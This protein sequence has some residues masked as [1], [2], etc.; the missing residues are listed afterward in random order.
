MLQ[1]RQRWLVVN[2]GHH[3]AT[4]DDW[5]PDAARKARPQS[6]RTSD[7]TL[8]RGSPQ[9]RV[10]ARRVKRNLWHDVMDDDRANDAEIVLVSLG[11]MDNLYSATSSLR[12]SHACVVYADPLRSANRY[13]VDG[14]SASHTVE[15]IITLCRAIKS[16]RKLVFVTPI[17]A[18]YMTIHHCRCPI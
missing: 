3:G 4:T 10:G 7:A 5:L 9:P 15:N 16:M 14:K 6:Q 1:V 18:G 2:R 12:L 17:P 8:I 11:A 13:G